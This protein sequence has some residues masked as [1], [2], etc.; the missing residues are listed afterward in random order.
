MDESPGDEHVAFK[1]WAESQ[2]VLIK[3]I[4]PARFP[5]R[6]LGMV[7]TR[8]IKEN[9]I[10]LSVPVAVMLT[11]DSIPSSFVRS[12]PAGTSIHG[13][14]AAFLTQGN[15]DLLSKWDTWRRVW[16]SWQEFEDSMP[17]FWPEQLRVSNSEFQK[18][19]DGGGSSPVLLPPSISG[20]WNSLKKR[21]LKVNYEMRYQ[22]LLRQQEKR[23]KDAWAHVITAYPETDWENFAHHWS[24]IN[25]RSFYYISPGKEE[26]E[27]WNDAIAMV[28]FADY[29]NHADDAACDVKFDGRKYTFMATKSYEK[30]EE[31]YM[32]YGSHSNDFL[33]VEYGFCLDEN[34]SDGIFLDDIILKALT[35]EE[36]KE[37]AAQECFGNY[38]ITSAGPNANT[39]LVACL[40]YMRR[41]DWL[42]Y[43]SGKSQRGFD[44]RKT[45]ALIC[46]WVD[47]YLE[48]SRASIGIIQDQY[49]AASSD[50]E[51]SIREKMD[52][53]LSR[54]KQIQEIC[55]NAVRVM[56]V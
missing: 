3:G 56:R 26:P 44:A 52:V 22:D 39:T 46:A 11:I 42:N 12:F 25:S 55:E 36:K 50:S 43:V 32:S 48:E 7:A 29:F 35:M 1:Q 5:G 17:V 33:L 8:A 37:L 30:G 21:Q 51:K 41:E 20:R 19:R 23:L 14:L 18:T 53:A 45:T 15:S 10:I 31:V 34:P 4:T 28:P 24:I 54:W 47:V 13:I 2:G 9:E 16:P 38:E 40:K 6:R 27:D 49:N